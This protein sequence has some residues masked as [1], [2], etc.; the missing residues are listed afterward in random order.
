MEQ[1]TV[2]EEKLNA[3]I[4]ICSVLESKVH[5]LIYSDEDTSKQLT[6]SS[7]NLLFALDKIE[8]L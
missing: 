2:G 6:A 7:P 8:K 1:F 4:S 5:L 3:A